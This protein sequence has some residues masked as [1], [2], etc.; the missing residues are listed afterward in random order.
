M[1][2]IKCDYLNGAV[3][4]PT[5]IIDKHLKLA[6]AAS[7]KVLLF[8]LRNPQGTADAKQISMCTGLSED[9]VEIC[10]EFWESNSVIEITDEKVT[11]ENYANSVGNAKAVTVTEEKKTERKVTVKKLPVKKPTQR[12]IAERLIAEPELE[13]IYQEAQNILGTFGYDTQAL[14]LMIYDFYGFPPEVIITLLQHQKN[15]GKTASSAIK[16]IA[17]DWAKRGID[18]LE[19]VEEELLALDKIK[20]TFL[21]VKETAE[22]SG[23]IPTTR[24][25]KFLRTWAV[26]WECSDELIKY[27]LENNNKSLNDTNK[28][29]KKFVQSGISSP[30]QVITREKKSLPKT[31]KKTYETEEIGKNSVLDW[32]K[33]YANGEE[34]E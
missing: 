3:A 22:F 30:E 29:L 27:A 14:L 4:V 2:K 9:D 17:E 23:D 24:I 32:I 19:L 13:I 12:E 31:V 1:I 7:F 6:S 25:A 8:I 18:T 5:E 20:A 34:N 15:E 10:L 33:K 21:A 26:D 16:N 28:M 11:E